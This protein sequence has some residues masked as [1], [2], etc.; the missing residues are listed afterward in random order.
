MN[1][2]QKVAKKSI[3]WIIENKKQFALP[4]NNN[5]KLII[6]LKPLGELILASD[7]MCS[8]FPKGT[9]FYQSGMKIL[10]FCW[11]ELKQFET[12]YETLENRPDLVILGTIYLSFVKH[13]FR[14]KKFEVLLRV[15]SGIKGISSLEFPAWRAIELAYAYNT[16][17]I[18]SVWN[19]NSIFKNTWIHQLPEPWS[20][21]NSS[22]YSLTHTIF[23]LTN[24]GAS[25]NKLPKRHRKYLQF[26]IPVWLQY[27]HEIS[28]YDLFGEFIMVLRCINERDEEDW[29]LYLSHFQEANGMI[30]G[31]PGARQNLDPFTKK[32]LRKTFLE[33]YH[34]TLVG[35]MAAAMS[36]AEL[37]KRK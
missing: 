5:E 36:L 27:Y 12:V 35:L 32:P 33:N 28:N 3:K 8:M 17:K 10:N 4:Q 15:I 34:T 2:Y 23:Y 16:L 7:M 9:K 14:N 1:N 11:K 22:A 26:W 24:F 25:P 19:A 31:P 30:C 37:R 20:L 18:K 21:S 29:G 13:G 6:M